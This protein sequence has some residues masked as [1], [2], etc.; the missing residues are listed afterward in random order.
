M[1]DVVHYQ[2]QARTDGA[3]VTPSTPL[4]VAIASPSATVTSAREVSAT[5]TPTAAAYSAND[6]MDVAKAFALIGPATGGKVY[7]VGT[8]LEIQ[9]TGLQSGETSYNLQIYSVTPPSALA[10]NAAWSLPSGDRASHLTTISLGTPVALGGTCKIEIDNINKLLTVPSGGSLYAYLVTV[11]G[12]TATAV[13][14][15]VTLKTVAV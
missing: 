13:A 15:K 12:F 8:V 5:F 7:L 1:S 2:N 4:P 6:T 14:R 3:L 9:T 10:D 11:G